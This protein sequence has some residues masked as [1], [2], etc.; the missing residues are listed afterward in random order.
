MAKIDNVPK[1]TQHCA[2]CG[3]DKH[4]DNSSFCSNCGKKLNYE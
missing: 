3:S 4:L 2:N 1:N